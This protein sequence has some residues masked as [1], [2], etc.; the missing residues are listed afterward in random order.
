MP[1]YAGDILFQRNYL[2]NILALNSFSTLVQKT[3]LD[4]NEENTK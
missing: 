4:V 3:G 2:N 1:I